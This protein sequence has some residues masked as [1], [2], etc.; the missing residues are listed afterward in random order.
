MAGDGK[1]I[2]GIIEESRSRE[3]PLIREYG[4]KVHTIT[5]EG[6]SALVS[7]APILPYE[8]KDKRLLAHNR[9]VKGVMKEYAILPMRFGTIA[10]DE[11]EVKRLL[12]QA[13]IPLR[14]ALA[15]IK[16]K[17]EFDLQVMWMGNEVFKMI[18]EESDLIRDYQER[19]AL[20]G[21]QVSLEEKITLG[22]LVADEVAKRQIVYTSEILESLKEVAIKATPPNR[23]T[24]EIFLSAA[25]LVEVDRIRSFEKRIYEMAERYD[26]MLKFKYT[27]PLPPYSFSVL[28]LLII[29]PERI[30]EAIG[31]LELTG[32]D[33]ENGVLTV[34][35]IQRAYHKMAKRYHP[36]RRPG[37]QEAE[38][39]FKKATAAYHLLLQCSKSNGSLLKLKDKEEMVVI[40]GNGEVG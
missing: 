11:C 36:D 9:V 2:Y 23:V 8:P 31:E 5:F 17:V 38:E 29:T 7:D 26:A 24:P 39:R 27:G 13:Y 35:D 14:E 16:G 21:S 33:K 3:F 18:A 22:R 28:K 4:A 6:L 15:G 19:I 34:T 25:F 10:R 20:L 40:V 30:D 1:Y 37:D 32:T 12:K